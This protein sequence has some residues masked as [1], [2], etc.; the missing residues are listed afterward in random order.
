MLA[1]QVAEKVE[2]HAEQVLTQA[3][4]FH[5]ASINFERF[6]EEVQAS[7]QLPEID[8]FINEFHCDTDDVILFADLPEVDEPVAQPSRRE[9]DRQPSKPT[10]KQPTNSAAE[11][12]ESSKLEMRT[13]FYSNQIRDHKKEMETL[14]E[15]LGKLNE[16]YQ[17]KE[18]EVLRTV[19][20]F[21]FVSNFQF[22]SI[23]RCQRFDTSWS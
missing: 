18:G 10:G 19:S 20:N 16:K 22:V 17:T 1:S 2:A 23:C 5:D 3:M 7:T 12:I 21:F 13:T 14:K 15:N 8:R 4:S 11:K 9:I 6:R